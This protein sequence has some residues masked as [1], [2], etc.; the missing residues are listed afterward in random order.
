MPRTREHVLQASFGTSLILATQVCAECNNA[1]S[2]IDKTFV[3]AVQFYHVGQNML[4]SLGL[5]RLALEDGTNV[6]AQYRQ[7]GQVTF[8][9]QFYQTTRND[10]KFIG[11]RASDFHAMMGELETPVNLQLRCSVVNR[12]VGDPPLSIVRSAPNAY[13]IKGSDPELV[14]RLYL[15]VREHGFR[16]DWCGTSLAPSAHEEPALQFNTALHLE[17]YC[18]AMAKVALNFVCYRM[19]VEVALR[20]E[21]DAIRKYARYGEGSFRDHVVPTLLNQEL[22]DSTAAFVR[23]RSHALLLAA[24]IMSD[25]HREA[26]FIT[27][28]GKTVGKVDISKEGSVLQLSSGV[29]LL[30]RF[31]GNGAAVEDLTLPD[32]LIRAVLNP[33]ALGLENTWPFPVEQE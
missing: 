17:P 8:P 19:G 10:W 7:N 20:P 22:E 29:Q 25:G 27:I 5:G 4:R 15:E 26:V 23:Q 28:C 13:L 21:L 30:T 12:V 32:D 11:S 2:P 16:P 14:E 1:F 6:I 3:E 33:A 31:D 24:A 9:P 18:R